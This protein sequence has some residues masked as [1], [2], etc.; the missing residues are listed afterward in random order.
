MQINVSTEPDGTEQDVNSILPGWHRLA[1]PVVIS[2]LSKTRDSLGQM[3]IHLTGVTVGSL[4][5][6]HGDHG[7]GKYFNERT[8]FLLLTF[9]TGANRGCLLSL[10][11][12]MDS[13]RPHNPWM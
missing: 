3:M 4:S 13:F 11:L 9:N 1:W 7:L 2:S 5:Y 10:M 8:V 6:L 12:Y